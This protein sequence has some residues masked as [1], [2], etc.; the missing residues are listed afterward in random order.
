MMELLIQDVW[1]WGPHRGILW[2]LFSW[3]HLQCCEHSSAAIYDVFITFACNPP[4]RACA[5]ERGSFGPLGFVRLQMQELEAVG[6]GAWLGVSPALWEVNS[7]PW[8]CCSLPSHRIFSQGFDFQGFFGLIVL[9][10]SWSFTVFQGSPTS[11]NYP[12]E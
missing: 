10:L 1:P 8:A 9:L 12:G 7:K 3:M 4:G 5:V 2:D 11:R 6:F